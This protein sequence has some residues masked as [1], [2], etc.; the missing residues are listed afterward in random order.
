MNNIEVKVRNEVNHPCIHNECTG[1]TCKTFKG[2][3]MKKLYFFLAVLILV[4][5]TEAYSQYSESFFSSNS[6]YKQELE[7]SGAKSYTIPATVNYKPLG[8]INWSEGFEDVTFPPSGWAVHQLDGGTNTWMRYTSTP[9]FGSASAAVRWE[10]STL[11]NDDWLVTP[12]FTVNPGAFLNFYAKR[13]SASYYDSVEIY[14][15]TSGGTPPSGYNYITTIMPAG[16]TGE[17]FQISLSSL[18]GQNIY[19]AFRYKELDQCRFYLDSV[20]VETPVALDAGVIAINSPKN[21]LTTLGTT[22]QIVVKNLGANSTGTFNAHITITPG[23]YHEMAT[24]PSLNSGESYTIDFSNWVPATAGTYTV[25]A[26]TDLSGDMNTQN[27]TL[28]KVVAV[29]EELYR[30]FVLNVSNLYPG[31]LSLYG[32]EFGNNYFYVS[33]WNE[34]KIFRINPSGTTI[35]SFTISGLTGGLRDLAWDGEFLYGSRSSTIVYKIDVNTFTATT[36]FTSPIS[37]RGIAY[38]AANDAFW[39]SNWNT[40]LRLVNRSGTTL[41]TIP[42]ASHGLTGMSGLA[43]D[44][45]TPDG[46]YLW[47]LNGGSA[48]DNKILYKLFAP[49]GTKVDSFLITHHLPEGSIGGGVFVADNVIPGSIT[50]GVLNQ[51][52]PHLITGYKIGGAALQPSLTLIHP[53][54]GE[55]FVNNRREIFVWKS[56][57]LSGNVNLL[58]STDNGLSWETI[59][60]N[61]PNTGFASVTTPFEPMSNLL[62]KVESVDDPTIFDIS[63]GYINIVEGAH[64]HAEFPVVV[65]D[66]YFAQALKMGLDST[67]TDGIDTHLGEYELPPVPPTSVFDAR[68]I[69][70]DIGIP[71]LGQGV[72]KDFRLGMPDFSGTK[73]HEVKYQRGPL[74]R[75]SNN[76]ITLYWSLPGNVVGRL[77]DVATG[78]NVI[79]VQMVGNDSYTVTNPDLYDKLKIT[80]TYTYTPPVTEF[81]KVLSPNGGE[82]YKRGENILIAWNSN[83]EGNVN[84]YASI[85]GG[86]SWIPVQLDVPNDGVWGTSIDYDTQEIT[87]GKIKVE[88]VN[89]PSIFDVSDNVFTVQGNKDA[90]LV[91]PFVISDGESSVALKYGLDPNATDGIDPVLGEAELPPPPPTGVFDGRFVGTDI[92]IPELGQ[93][94]LKDFRQGGATFS[95]TKVHEIQYQMGS[96][97]DSLR[98]FWYLPSNVTGLLQD[99]FGGGIVNVSMSGEGKF[100]V[101]NP[102]ILN[103]L[104]ITLTYTP[105]PATVTVIA[106]NGGENLVVG[107]TYNIQW[108]AT[109]IDNVK[110]EYTTDNGA[111]WIEIATVPALSKANDIYGHPKKRITN[112]ESLLGSYS[113]VVPNTP[114]NQCKVKVSDASNPSVFDES[115]GLFTI[116]APMTELWIT[117][118]SGTTATLYSVSAVNENVAWAC[119]AGGVVIRTTD[120]GT[121]WS[122]VNAPRAVDAYVIKGIDANKALVATSGANDAKIHLTTNGGQT[123]T[124][125]FTQPGGF[126]NVILMLDENNGFVEGDPV[127][128]S[129]TLLRTTDGGFTWTPVTLAPSGSEFGWNNS[130]WNYG[131]TIWFG[132][133]NSRIYKSTDGG[134]TWNFAPTTSTNS[135]AVAFNTANNGLAGFGSGVLNFSSNAGNSWSLLPFNAQSDVTGIGTAAPD[136]FFISAG[137]SIWYTPDNGGNWFISY[138]GQTPIYHVSFKPTT[139]MSS[140]PAVG[141]AVGPNGTVLKYRRQIQTPYVQVISPNGGESWLAGSTQ[142]IVWDAQLVSNVKLEYTT[143]NG[144]SWIYIDTATAFTSNKVKL[145]GYN[146]KDPKG[147]VTGNLGIY[148]WTVPNT[149]SDQCKVRVS[150][151]SNPTVYDESDNVFTITE[152][153]IGESWTVQ[154]S[155]TTAT[156]YSVSVVDDNVSWACGAGGVVIRTTNGGVT[157]TPVTSPRAVDAHVIKGIDANRAL[158]ATNGSTDAKIHLTTNGGQTWTDVFTQA[159]GFINV[160]VMFDDNNGFAEGDPVGGNWTLL[161]TTDGGATWAPAGTLPQ[162]GGE[163]GWNNSGWNVG[164]TI[165]FGTNNSRVY[166]STDGGNTWTFALTTVANSYAVTFGSAQKGFVGS[167]T[168]TANRSVDGGN[169]WTAISTPATGN[170]LGA[171]GL[172]ENEYWFTAGNNVYY[173]SDH[174]SN[175]STSFTG[176]NALYHINVKGL[177]GSNAVGYAVGANGYLVKYFRGPITP[178]ITVVSPNG[179][180]NWTVGSVRQI[181][182]NAQAVSTVKLEFSTNNGATWNFIGTAPAMANLRVNKNSEQLEFVIEGEMGV[183]NWTI[184]NTPSNQC[185]VKVSDNSNPS[186]YDVSD[187]VF[188]ISTG[189]SG[190]VLQFNYDISALYPGL[191]SAY[192]SEFDGEYFYLTIWNSPK[193]FRINK[194][195]TSIDSFNISGLAAGTGL[196]DLAFDGMYLYGS[197]NTTTVYRIDRTTFTA[198][199]AFTSPIAVR[200][201]SYDAEHDAFW[202]ANWSTDIVLVSRTGATLYTIPASA[203]GFTGMS[204]NAYDTLSPGGPYLWIFSGGTQTDPKVL[205]KINPQ[206]GA[207]LDSIDV[208]PILPDGAIGGGLW[209]TDQFMPQ[210]VTLGGS[211]QATPHRLFGYQIHVQGPI[212]GTVTVLSPNGGEVFY[213]GQIQLIT[214]KSYEFDSKVKIRISSDGGNTFFSEISNINNTGVYAVLVPNDAQSGQ[215]YKIRIEAQSDSTKFD[216]SDGTYTIVDAPYTLPVVDLPMVVSDQVNSRL[217]RFGL[218]TAATDGIDPQFGEEELP[219]VPPVGV[220]DARFV[221]D[222][223]S[224]P[225]LGQ[226]LLYDYRRGRA[227][228]YSVK[229]HEL[230]FQPGSGNDIVI[231]LYLPEDVTAR[232]ESFVPGF[233]TTV[234]GVARVVVSDSSINKLKV[235]INYFP[236]SVL[237][238]FDLFGPINN[239]L[240]TARQGDSTKVT[241]RWYKARSAVQY[242]LRMGIPTIPPFML[243]VLSNNSGSDTVYTTTQAALYDHF[244][245]L[246]FP[247]K[248]SIYTGQWAVWAYDING[249]S[250][251]SNSIRAIRIRLV[252]FVGVDNEAQIP[253]KF[254]V[255][256]NYP[257]PFNPST[258]IKYGI[259]TDAEVT[260]EI[261]NIVGEKITTLYEGQRKAG[262]HET[263]FDASNLQSGVYFYKVIAGNTSSVKKMLLMK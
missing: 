201:I 232:F 127:G 38:D 168:G 225:Q 82:V 87:N 160:I 146:P 198:T 186:V 67:A 151:V 104:K 233:D 100:T 154:N 258:K 138:M 175:W 96:S 85:D 6:N 183:Y 197:N 64:P 60:S 245:G 173:S 236:S 120:G 59:L 244:V 216:E 169:S 16:T 27:D 253:D 23:S 47:V 259:P 248:D 84:I 10:S 234:S 177:G 13:Q 124:D 57:N 221:G 4:F 242:R 112:T 254:V 164:N 148:A 9:I 219:P 97:G 255:Y 20:Y 226:G 31:A 1:L 135:Y 229:L 81:I 77:Q 155:N 24:V 15:S 68:L 158:V 66:G 73:I 262:Y 182:W 70:S 218:D 165:W 106:P 45:L 261:Y 172:N 156:L 121:T 103:K 166:K 207:R 196:R 125:V 3:H 25:T 63:D 18:A 252:P 118:N 92:G 137:T 228:S 194:E 142:Y 115:D 203:H 111:N 230:K 179:G 200:G 223:I 72:L 159:G 44:T 209:V 251:R 139:T 241:F 32:V 2:E 133:N 108:D 215:D 86:T 53:N 26:W 17:L 109:G 50:L 41:Q 123:W 94:V 11:S 210:T 167:A 42:A 195:G 246:G 238:S 79:D 171:S 204:G 227:N 110:L 35:D 49:T 256:Q 260:I 102:S 54:G 224:L 178:Q 14:Y 231:N 129:W 235:T 61:I 220:L 170:I 131:N 117:Q 263:T 145:D 206:N 189:V 90:Y 37:V 147:T 190:P 181:V 69:G 191:I 257:N 75:A 7:K 76:G 163:Y 29:T 211:S 105:V 184:P 136:E 122:V 21:I 107:S 51:G 101:P 152:G 56:Q 162:S 99:F 5:V 83:V 78:G 88:S 222:D 153:V 150:D 132:T 119:G 98:V 43:Y 143:D 161:R 249:D 93:G 176:S 39:V 65:S 40:D 243:D 126:L 48:T 144:Q 237:G 91:N 128:N 157:W 188:T 202:V 185:L 22:P 58:A 19:I 199:P 212:P 205:Y 208:T 113:W 8:V 114:S 28:V 217:L 214:W 116:S 71:E 55:S 46:P 52:T 30:D 180:E 192:G 89:N 213:K 34:N 141:W 36:A 140:Q 134:L 149:P 240:I 174:G 187:N 74:A 130:G 33:K 250:L 62:V 80:Y 12:Q 193:M 95:G 247:T 239:A